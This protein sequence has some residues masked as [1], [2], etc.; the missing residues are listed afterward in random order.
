MKA[1][2]SQPL[3]KTKYTKL[4]LHKTIKFVSLMQVAFIIL[5]FG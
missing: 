5:K 1:F 3:T 2:S 4:F